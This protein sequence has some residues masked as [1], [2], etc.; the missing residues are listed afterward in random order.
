M[1]K[2]KVK[3]NIPPFIHCGKGLNHWYIQ[4]AAAVFPLFLLISIY[5]IQAIPVA[6]LSTAGFL[7]GE[8][9]PRFI[10][11]NKNNIKTSYFRYVLGGLLFTVFTAS[12]TENFTVNF[13]IP[14][15]AAFFAPA[16]SSAASKN[17]YSFRRGMF[18]SFAIALILVYSFSGNVPA[19]QYEP[20]AVLIALS[21][22][23]V[24]LLVKRKL[25]FQIFAGIACAALLAYII[26]ADPRIAA[27]GLTAVVLSYPG[28]IPEGAVFRMFFG[29]AA[30]LMIIF[31]GIPGFLASLLLRSA[32]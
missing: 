24:I 22:G 30:S 4:V 18:P 15:W 3:T 6:L 19:I 10:R 28:L 1:K 27:P 8:K 23:I 20:A 13:T 5:R 14:L 9:L 12:V 21:A 32:I 29:F 2:E 17:I 25:P 31:F 11:G 16:F 7:T 26:T